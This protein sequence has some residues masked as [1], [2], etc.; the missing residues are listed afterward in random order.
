M[1]TFRALLR[2]CARPVTQ[3]SARALATR[4]LT[5]RPGRRLAARA[6]SYPAHEVV[7]LPALSPTMEVGTIQKWHVEE[8]GSFGEGD[9]ICEIETDKATIDFTA[10]DEGVVARLLQPE[11]TEIAIGT[12]ILVKVEDAA[13]AGA[14]ADFEAPAGAVAAP[15]PAAAPEPAPAP[16]APAAAAPVA[17]APVVAA[18][19]GAGERPSVRGDDSYALPAYQGNRNESFRGIKL[20]RL[21][22]RGPGAYGDDD[23]DAVPI[24]FSSTR[25][26][27]QYSAK[28]AE[29]LRA[30]AMQQQKAEEGAAASGGLRQ[31]A[32]AYT[33]DSLLKVERDLLIARMQSADLTDEASAHDM[34]RLM[35]ELDAAAMAPAGS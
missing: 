26:K 3:R 9:T 1:R 4:A 31:M 27:S 25:R 17:A 21:S 8:G 30:E 29:A 33:D 22:F 32:E 7:G 6:L 2:P 18:A 23:D 12:P 34:E 14:F 16:V 15:A 35:E 5:Q 13:D 19:S 11:G 28:R 20:D 24:D 10:Q